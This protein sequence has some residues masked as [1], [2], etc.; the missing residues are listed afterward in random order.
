MK[1][2]DF[3]TTK[4]ARHTGAH[5]SSTFEANSTSQPSTHWVLWSII[6]KFK[7]IFGSAFNS[8]IK[9]AWNTIIGIIDFAKSKFAYTKDELTQNKIH[10]DQPP[11]YSEID[12]NGGKQRQLEEQREL[13]KKQIR[14]N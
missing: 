7:S 13:A 1:K 10:H 8:C 6:L 9:W 14:V 3:I 4:P 11:L 5:A 12:N 2:G